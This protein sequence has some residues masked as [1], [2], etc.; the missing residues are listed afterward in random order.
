MTGEVVRWFGRRF[1]V[2]G[3]VPWRRCTG[4]FAWTEY[5]SAETAQRTCTVAFA[6]ARFGY[7]TMK[8]IPRE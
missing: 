2:D 5:W 6:A 8:L 7:A 3:L 1:V 4:A